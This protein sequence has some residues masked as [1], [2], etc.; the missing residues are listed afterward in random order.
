MNKIEALQKTIYN[1]ENDVYEYNWNSCDTCNCGILARTLMN[2]SY[3]IRNGLY[4]SPVSVG[5][6]AFS[7]HAYCLKTDLPLPK[8]FQVLKNAGFN[9]DD[10]VE[11]ELLGNKEV[12]SRIGYGYFTCYYGRTIIDSLAYGNKEIVV[13]YMKAWV[14]ILKEEQQPTHKDETPK[15][16]SLIPIVDEVSDV[17]MNKQT[18]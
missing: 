7:R 16:T 3:A 15:F 18:V 14:E 8:V 5:N 2:G 12:L 6:G 11:L 10:M 1:L 13:K 17:V 4:N 9:Y